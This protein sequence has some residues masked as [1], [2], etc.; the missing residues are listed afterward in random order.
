MKKI[1]LQIITNSR[2]RKR[3]KYRSTGILLIW[4]LF[5][6]EKQ[7]NS[8]KCVILRAKL[9]LK[10]CH[11]ATI[12]T[13]VVFHLRKIRQILKPNLCLAK[14]RICSFLHIQAYD[15]IHVYILKFD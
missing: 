2:E 9:Y 1:G 13:N 7:V 4:E 6:I 14:T 15:K 10:D 11:L 5:R 3:K 12:A 8:E